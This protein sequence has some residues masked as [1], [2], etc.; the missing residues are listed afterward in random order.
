M[1][2]TLNDS[3]FKEEEEDESPRLGADDEERQTHDHLDVKA[4]CDDTVVTKPANQGRAKDH[5]NLQHALLYHLLIGLYIRLPSSRIN[6]GPSLTV[7]TIT[8]ITCNNMTI[9]S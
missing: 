4:T 7:L 8:T 1:K 6:T 5:H 2:A 3:L 9:Y